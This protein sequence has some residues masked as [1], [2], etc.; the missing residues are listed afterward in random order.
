MISKKL[1]A[2]VAVCLAI[3]LAAVGA[4][5]YIVMNRSSTNKTFNFCWTGSVAEKFNATT[6]WMNVTFDRVNETHLIITVKVNDLS[7]QG[8]HVGLAGD[9]DGDGEIDGG[10]LMYCAGNY[11]IES[12][13]GPWINGQRFLGAIIDGIDFGWHTC[14]FDPQ[15]GYTYVIPTTVTNATAK[16][17]DLIH[18]EYVSI[19]AQERVMVEFRFGMELIA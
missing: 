1:L 15:Q 14:V 19:G 6:F 18:V 2:V 11:T 10:G 3:L 13:L 8:G 16:A 9:G 4:Y 5:V 17:S 7:P 12:C